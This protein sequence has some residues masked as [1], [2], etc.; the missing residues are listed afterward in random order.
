MKETEK[1]INREKGEEEI[2]I[3]TKRLI[4]RKRKNEG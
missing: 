3:E 4:D 1:D 2:K